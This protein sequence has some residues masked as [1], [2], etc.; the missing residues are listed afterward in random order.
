[1]QLLLLLI[2]LLISEFGL[3]TT[4]VSVYNNVL[5]IRQGLDLVEG[6]VPLVGLAVELGR[7][8]LNKK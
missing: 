5:I 1:M 7:P 6:L 2:S 8:Y 4:N 3:K